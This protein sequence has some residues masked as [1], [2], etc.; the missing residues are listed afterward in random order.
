[1]HHADNGQHEAPFWQGN[2]AAPAKNRHS[3]RDAQG[4]LR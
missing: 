1:M 2:C 4:V 3:F